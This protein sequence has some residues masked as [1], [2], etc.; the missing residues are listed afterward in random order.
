M[1]ESY[2][3][4]RK[5]EVVAYYRKCKS[6]TRTAAKFKVHQ[7]DNQQRT[8]CHA[9]DKWAVKKILSQERKNMS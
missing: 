9:P 6:V 1:K 4:G 7:T 5:I 8:P 3:E 2:S